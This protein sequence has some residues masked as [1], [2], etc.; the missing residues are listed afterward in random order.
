MKKILIIAVAAAI[1]VLS[2]SESGHKPDAT[3]ASTAEVT[4]APEALTSIEWL[5]STF[6]KGSITEGEKLEIVYRFKN[7]GDKPLVIKS[8][9]GSCG[10][11]VPERPEEPIAAGKEGFIKATFDS[12]NRIGPNHKTVTVEANTSP[13]IYH[14]SFDV[15]VNKK[16]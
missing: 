11:T 10:C 16:S 1:T 6:N 12:H 9:K 7:T 14:L 3:A 4:A 2:C 5:D 13:A 8:A 15:V